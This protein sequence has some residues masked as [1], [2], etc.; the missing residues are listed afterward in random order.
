MSEHERLRVES[1]ES[2]W[3]DSDVN[4]FVVAV[5]SALQFVAVILEWECNNVGVCG[6]A[7][8]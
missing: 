4:V 7:F 6:C 2:A 5:A 8:Q 3:V 1:R